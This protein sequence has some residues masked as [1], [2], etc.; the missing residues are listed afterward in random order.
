MTESLGLRRRHALAWLAP[1]V[2]LLTSPALCRADLLVNDLAENHGPNWATGQ[3]PG[4]V[5]PAVSYGAHGPAAE[6]PVLAMDAGGLLAL[7]GVCVHPPIDPPHTKSSGSGGGTHT[8]GGGTA[9]G[10]E[11]GGGGIVSVA[12]T[13]PEPTGLL[14]GTVGAGLAAA[15]EL[16]RKKLA[17]R[18]V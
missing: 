13:S 8:G 16:L 10:G 11:G 2:V 3:P 15:A 5:A 6:A 14:I 18:L 4:H 17:P 12:S 9:I 7:F 1:T